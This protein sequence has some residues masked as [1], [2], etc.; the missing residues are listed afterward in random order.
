MSTLLGDGFVGGEDLLAFGDAERG[1]GLV[2]TLAA[3][4]VDLAERAAD[5]WE[6]CYGLLL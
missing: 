5:R 1:E 6:D 2:E 3:G 4:G